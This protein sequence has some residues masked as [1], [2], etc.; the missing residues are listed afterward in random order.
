MHDINLRTVDA[1]AEEVV[2]DREGRAGGAVERDVDGV[3]IVGGA[4]GVRG[5]L[6]MG[7]G[8]DLIVVVNVGGGEGVL[9]LL[10]RR[11]PLHNHV[12]SRASKS[13]LWRALSGGRCSLHLFGL[14]EVGGQ[15]RSTS[16]T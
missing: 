10:H 3:D 11:I 9:L 5:V 13:V 6:R 12:Y 15:R 14:L 1:G 8:G 4:R 7:N 16:A 2:V